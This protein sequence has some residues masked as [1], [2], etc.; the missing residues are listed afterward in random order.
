MPLVIRERYII[1][2]YIPS[3][4]LAEQ[5]LGSSNKGSIQFPLV[6]DGPLHIFSNDARQRMLYLIS[7]LARELLFNYLSV[8]AVPSFQI[9]KPL[10]TS[11]KRQYGNINQQ[12][13]KL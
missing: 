2:L 3:V 9:R 8:L 12:N 10:S 4:K 1:T 13:K 7:I 11:L 5:A 6:E